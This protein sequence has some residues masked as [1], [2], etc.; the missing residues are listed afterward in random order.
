MFGTTFIENNE[1]M[2]AEILEE[3]LV[4]RIRDLAKKDMPASF[5]CAL[6]AYAHMWALANGY[7]KAEHEPE[8][9]HEAKIPEGWD[10]IDNAPQTDPEVS[11][12]RRDLNFLARHLC[13]TLPSTYVEDDEDED[14]GFRW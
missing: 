4:Q 9:E 11:A 3:A 1:N 7:E 14:E 13:L 8:A 2:D 12:L 5:K 10:A 6:Q